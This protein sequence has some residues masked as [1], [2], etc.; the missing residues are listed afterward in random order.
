MT[1]QIA[2]A[3]KL[4]LSLITIAAACA[5]A[6]PASAQQASGKSFVD[7]FD[8]IN[9]G[10]WY[11]SDGWN[12]GAH[13]NCTWSKNNVK[14]ENGALQLSF[15]DGKSKD[16]NYSC[17]EI[18]T[19]KRYGYGTYEARIKAGTGS[20]LNS[21]FFTYIGP[22]DKQ[23]HDEIDFEVLGKNT[24]EVQVNQYVQAKGGNEKLV[25]VG[26]KADE[27]F[28]DYAFIWEKDR[29]RY[30]LNGKLVQD[31]TDP[32]KIPSTPQKIFFSLWGSDTLSNWMGRFDYTK[33]AVLSVER[34][35]FT[36]LGDKCQFPESI[37][38]T[39]N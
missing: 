38:C 6:L 31:V 28:N 1:T 12:N 23:K 37:A 39:L 15:A 7:D 36:A 27:G 10:F 18:Q 14:V 13:Q 24:G 19:T 33:P 2:H 4:C 9:R 20:G 25:P 34:V 35:A 5:S 17:G 32:S 3:R 29:L 26:S 21:A 22:A 8:K 30:Y 16:R 11:V